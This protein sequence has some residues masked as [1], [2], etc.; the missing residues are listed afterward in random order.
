[1]SFF[2]SFIGMPIFIKHLIWSIHPGM[3]DGFCLV[4]VLTCLKV[5]LLKSMSCWRS[6]YSDRSCDSD[7]LFSS[8]SLSSSS[9]I[10]RTLLGLDSSATSITWLSS[11]SCGS[12][13][14]ECLQVFPKLWSFL[15]PFCHIN[16]CQLHYH[17][18]ALLHCILCL[19]LLYY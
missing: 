19:P 10:W 12:Y 4:L 8:Y 1:M 18:L 2:S 13:F 15:D 9:S 5:A 16:H 3:F 14:S 7:S 17:Y 11:C 6:R